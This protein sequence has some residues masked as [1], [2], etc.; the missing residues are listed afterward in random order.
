MT[1]HHGVR[2]SS[3]VLDCRLDGCRALLL[4]GSA[5]VFIIFITGSYPIATLAAIGTELL[6]GCRLGLSLG[7]DW[8]S[9]GAL[10]DI[11]QSVT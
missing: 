4:Q 5:S 1:I 11:A 3:V 6:C 2:S 9:A 7:G 10:K 8:V